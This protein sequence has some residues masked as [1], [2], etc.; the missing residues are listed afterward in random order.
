MPLTTDSLGT[1]ACFVA[2]F[3]LL[4]VVIT[5]FVLG[6]YYQLWSSNQLDSRASR[7]K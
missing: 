2:E 5:L 4:G 6:Q 1:I 3:F 7:P